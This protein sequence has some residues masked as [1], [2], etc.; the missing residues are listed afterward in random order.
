MIRHARLTVVVDEQG[1]RVRNPWRSYAINWSEVTGATPILTE[2][3]TPYLLPGLRRSGALTA[4]RLWALAVPAARLVVKA[5]EG[6]RRQWLAAV[7][8]QWHKDYGVRVRDF[9]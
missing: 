9:D 5:H 7:V 8:S 3:Q 4:I 2:S 1:V 6:D